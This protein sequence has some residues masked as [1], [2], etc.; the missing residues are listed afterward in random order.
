MEFEQSSSNDDFPIFPVEL[1]EYI[2]SVCCFTQL[3]SLSEINVMFRALVILEVKKRLNNLKEA[4]IK[5]GLLLT[6]NPI[7]FFFNDFYSN[8]NCIKNDD[9]EI[10]ISG[11]DFVLRFLELFGDQIN[12]MV[13]NFNNASEREANLVFSRVIEYCPNLNTLVFGNLRHSL[14][15]SLILPLKN[16][17]K[18]FFQ[19]CWLQDSLCDLNVYFPNVKTLTFSE[20]NCYEFGDNLIRNYPLLE[21]FDACEASFTLVDVFF[22][23]LLNPQAIVY[24]RPIYQVE[25]LS[26]T[27]DDF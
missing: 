4:T 12:Y 26:L 24:S 22:L 21:R 14:R 27:A 9:N 1:F 5:K 2:T 13:L 17:E 3:L 10:S 7:C 19:Y 6:E 16:I 15:N 23:Q 25:T 11:I 8:V 20:M 18:L